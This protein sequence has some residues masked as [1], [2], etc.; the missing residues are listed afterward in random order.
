MSVCPGA[1][2]LS[3][4]PWGRTWSCLPLTV[5]Q[6]MHLPTNSSTSTAMVSQNTICSRRSR[7]SALLRCPLSPPWASRMQRCRSSFTSGTYT[8]P[9]MVLYTLSV[10]S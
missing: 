2:P 1:L 9:V 6:D 8:A 3:A 5:R 4:T 10:L 7:V